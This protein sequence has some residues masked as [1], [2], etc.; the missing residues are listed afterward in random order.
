MKK[1]ILVVDDNESMRKVIKFALEQ[2]KHEVETAINGREAWQTIENG[3]RP[4][5]VITDNEMPEVNGVILTAAIKDNSKIPVI[6]MSGKTPPA[7]K[8]DIFLSK[9]FPRTKLIEAVESLLLQSTC[10][11]S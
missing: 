3:N 8:A 10:K 9:P 11:E 4:D 1:K 6:L 7:N 5:L 2:E